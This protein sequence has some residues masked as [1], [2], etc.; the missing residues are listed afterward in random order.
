MKAE[1]V[2]A[3]PKDTGYRVG[4]RYLSKSELAAIYGVTTRTLD[5][6]LAAGTLPQPDR[7]PSGRPRWLESVARSALRQP[8]AA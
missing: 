7:T 2:A 4:E 3:T 6:W 1:Q 8:S 5:N